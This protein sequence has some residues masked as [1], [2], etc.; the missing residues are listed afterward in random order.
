MQ[1]RGPIGPVPL[2]WAINSTKT[3]EMLHLRGNNS[4]VDIHIFM[5]L[6]TWLHLVMSIIF[7]IYTIYLSLII[8]GKNNKNV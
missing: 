1:T 2:T 7:A 6:A 3:Q 5:K 8:L 4:D